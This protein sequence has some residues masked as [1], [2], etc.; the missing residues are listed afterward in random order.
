MP[1][2]LRPG[3]VPD[4]GAITELPDTVV[5]LIFGD[6]GAGKTRLIGTA[7]GPILVIN[8]DNSVSTLRGKEGISVYP[9]PAL[10]KPVETWDE[11]LSILNWLENGG[12]KG[13]TTVAFDTVTEAGSLLIKKILS[14]EGPT[15][16]VHPKV[17]SQADYGIFGNEMI[18]FVRRVRDLRSNV[19]MTAQIDD[20]L[21][22]KPEGGA[23]MFRMPNFGTGKMAQQMSPQYFDLVGYLG[24]EAIKGGG[25]VRKLLTQPIGNR[26]AKIR[27]PEGVESP[28]VIEDPNLTKIFALI[29]GGK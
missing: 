7:P 10:K 8:I 16:R 27:T 20:L 5:S 22:E 9:N 15:K 2:V 6:P 19:V 24:V 21:V 28:V 14:A 1:G 29:T 3:Q 25:L 26:K 4:F 13:F 18:D 11:L 17:L 23:E 12:T